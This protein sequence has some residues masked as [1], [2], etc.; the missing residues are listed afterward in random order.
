MTQ[1]YFACSFSTILYTIPINPYLCID[2]LILDYCE[3][4]LLH[5]SSLSVASAWE[6]QKHAQY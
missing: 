5:I 1:H 4:H 2:M 3:L 6:M